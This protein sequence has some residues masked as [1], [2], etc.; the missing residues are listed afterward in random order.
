M[1][2]P[3][4][5]G[6]P[7][8]GIK[9]ESPESASGYFIPESPGRPCH[10]SKLLKYYQIL[11]CTLYPHDTCVC[12]CAPACCFIQLFA[13]LETIAHQ[14]PP[15]RKFSKQE[16]WSGFPFPTPGDPSDPGIKTA[17][18]AYP[19]LA[20]TTGKPSY[21]ITGRFVPLNPLHLFGSTPTSP[22]FVLF[23]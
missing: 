3:S 23:L 20:G 16:Y 13:N 17:S 1:P 21:F 12:V 10:H 7:D 8:P 6:L 11:H 5:G 18:L 2:F 15:C 19:A 22:V 14:A 9:P 4:P